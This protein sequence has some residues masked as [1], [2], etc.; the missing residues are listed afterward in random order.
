M[1]GAMLSVTGSGSC[2]LPEKIRLVFVN[3]C[4][5]T[6][7]IRRRSVSGFAVPCRIRRRR[8]SESARNWSRFRA[9]PAANRQGPAVLNCRRYSS[10]T[11]LKAARF[12]SQPSSS[13]RPT[14]A[15]VLAHLAVDARRAAR[16]RTAET[17]VQYLGD[18]GGQC[19]VG[20]NDAAAFTRREALGGVGN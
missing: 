4:R 16:A 15:W 13:A 3:L 1:Q 6:G 9:P 17:V 12:A 11:V 19:C 14:A 8:Y 18:S 20:G 5:T 10:A 7:G 2:S